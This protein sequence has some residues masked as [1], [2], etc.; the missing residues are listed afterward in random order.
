MDYYRKYDYYFIALGCTCLLAF[1]AIVF[2]N[3]KDINTGTTTMQVMDKK[4]VKQTLDDISQKLDIIRQELQK[5]EARER[6]L[7]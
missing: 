2:L 1:L 6:E 4:T 5:L 3:P 7:K